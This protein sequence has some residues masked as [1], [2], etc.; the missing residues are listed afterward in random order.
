[1]ADEKLQCGLNQVTGVVSMNTH[2]S[3]A[4]EAT[5]PLHSLFREP[6]A[7]H[8]ESS[9]PM[10]AQ[11]AKGYKHDMA[12][13]LR[14]STEAV[15]G[16]HSLGTTA[17]RYAPQFTHLN[18]GPDTDAAQEAEKQ[19]ADNLKSD[20]TDYTSLTYKNHWPSDAVQVERSAKGDLDHAGKFGHEVTRTSHRPSDAVK[21]VQ[22]IP[23]VDE[24]E[25]NLLFG[26][27][28]DAPAPEKTTHEATGTVHRPT[29]AVLQ[30]IISAD[31]DN[32]AIGRFS[33]KKSRHRSGQDQG[34]KLNRES[35]TPVV[36]R[37]SPRFYAD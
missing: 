17:G 16:E 25:R 37:K 20:A 19:S 28:Q 21:I 32:D 11:R 31:L 4:H 8:V 36:R 22:L 30:K 33:A 5:C 13:P 27:I 15:Q 12:C 26:G 34:G 2:K 6:D 35:E 3:Y 7:A 14:R 9:A 29:D 24:Q 18:H 10:T 23:S 1:M